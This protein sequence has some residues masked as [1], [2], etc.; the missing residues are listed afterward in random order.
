MGDEEATVMFAVYVVWQERVADVD[1]EVLP[2]EPGIHL[3]LRVS[4]LVDPRI[5]SVGI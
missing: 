5:E 3:L 2:V 1:F 4:N